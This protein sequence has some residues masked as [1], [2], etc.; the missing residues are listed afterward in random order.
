MNKN[1]LA[2]L[3][4]GIWISLSEFNRNELL[5]KTYWLQKYASL[6]LQ[7]PSGPINNALWGIWSFL[8]T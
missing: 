2:F 8:L 3:A 7:F 6:G 4:A 5:F 1:I